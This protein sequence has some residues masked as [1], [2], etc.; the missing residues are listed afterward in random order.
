MNAFTPQTLPFAF[1][2][3]DV[4]ND[5]DLDASITRTGFWGN[6]FHAYPVKSQA[7]FETIVKKRAKLFYDYVIPPSALAFQKRNYADVMESNNERQKA[8]YKDLG[9]TRALYKLIKFDEQRYSII[10][11]HERDPDSFMLN[12]YR[13]YYL[14][15]PQLGKYITTEQARFSSP[16]APNSEERGRTFLNTQ[17]VYTS[18]ETLKNT[19]AMAVGPVMWLKPDEHPVINYTMKSPQANMDINLISGG[20]TDTMAEVKAAQN[21]KLIQ[22]KSDS[23]DQSDVLYKRSRDVLQMAGREV[24]VFVPKNDMNIPRAY[25]WCSWATAGEK[26]NLMRPAIELQAWIY[27]SEREDGYAKALWEQLVNSLKSRGGLAQNVANLSVGDPCPQTGFWMCDQLG[28]EQ[29]IFLRKGD[30][31]PGQSFSAA[32]RENMNWRLIK[33]VA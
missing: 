30:P 18:P 12:V 1:Y 2:Q 11:T 9:M 20:V 28:G 27:V 5:I 14:Y 3:I 22:I 29:G 26:N 15:A 21:Q 16:D 17:I 25:Y 23:S 32:E 31:M 13:Q 10:A 19:H 4:P 8:A 24:C 6:R 33:P 7:E